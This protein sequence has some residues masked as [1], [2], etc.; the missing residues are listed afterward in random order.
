MPRIE[1][2]RNAS[3]EIQGR[4]PS[5]IHGVPSGSQWAPA[6]ME[7]GSTRKGQLDMELPVRQ[8][9]PFPCRG[10]DYAAPTPSGNVLPVSLHPEWSALDTE[11]S[12]MGSLLAL[13][14]HL[15]FYERLRQA[16]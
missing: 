15:V 13:N 2:A 6:S 3:A 7:I 16:S 4:G 11:S 9:P 8:T 10:C 12:V 14:A 1:K 5:E